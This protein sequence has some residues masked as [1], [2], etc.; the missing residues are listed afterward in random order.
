MLLFEIIAMEVLRVQLVIFM[1]VALVFSLLLP[2][3]TAQAPAPAP[4]PSSDGLFSLS[5]SLSP[6]D[7]SNIIYFSLLC[8][9]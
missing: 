1:L 3:T 8:L 2:S 7:L 9:F 6:P 4:P 5:L